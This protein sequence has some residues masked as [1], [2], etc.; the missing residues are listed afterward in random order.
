MQLTLKPLPEPRQPIRYCLWSALA[1][2]LANALDYMTTVMALK[3]GAVEQNPLAQFFFENW[4]NSG[5]LYFK[6][7]GTLLFIVL[8]WRK[9]LL[10]LIA[11]SMYCAV[12][13]SNL[14]VIYQLM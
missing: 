11:V 1:V 4:G 5:L 8:A 9:R 6:L 12:S 14:W 13:L 7:C 10:A 3:I 2:V